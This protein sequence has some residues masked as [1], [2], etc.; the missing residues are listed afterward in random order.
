[1]NDLKL[2]HSSKNRLRLFSKEIN[3]LTDENDLYKEISKIKDIQDFRINKRASCIIIKHKSKDENNIIKTLKKIKVLKKEK[4]EVNT[5]VNELIKNSSS[6]F[7]TA[8]VPEFLKPIVSFYFSKTLLKEGFDDLVKIGISSRFLEAIAVG[9]SILRNDYLSA[10]TTN[11]LLSLGEYIEESTSN[12]SDELLKDLMKPKIKEVWIDNEGVEEL[13]PYKKLKIGNIVIINAGDMVPIDGT[14]LSG[15]ALVNQSSMTGEALSVKKLRGDRVI[16]GTLVEEGRIKVWAEN[17]GEDTA[18]AKITKYIQSSLKEKSLAQKKANMLAEKLV[19]VT[20]ALASFAY[21]STR[22][23]N[24]VSAVLQAD[25]SCALKLASP[26]TF[27]SSIHKAGRVGIMVKGAK[28]IE[29]LSEVDTFVF[30][31]TGTLTK[32]DL[33][34]NDVISFDKKWDKDDILSLA[35]SAEEHYFHPVA[36]AIVK[37]AKNRNFVH[38]NH[39]EVDFI[40]AHGVSTIVEGNKRVLIGSRHFLEDDEKISFKAYNKII[41]EYKKTGRNLLFVAYDNKLLAMISL[42]DTIREDSKKTI[43]KLRLNGVKNIIMLTGDEEDKA[44]E[45]AKKLNID[46]VYAQLKPKQ[47]AEIVKKLKKQGNKVAFVGDGINDAPALISADVGI[48]MQRAAE[49]AGAS[50]DIALL[51]DSIS[52]INEIKEL[53]DKTMK[54]VKRNFN[55]TVWAN[56]SILILASLGKISPITT[57]ILHNGTTVALLLNAIKGIKK[58]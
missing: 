20:I 28:A 18:V 24:R 23:F 9:I 27:K 47:K 46:K 51:V 40:V 53:S 43:E 41:Q 39:N 30:D 3:S 58:T 48:N 37:A 34:V 29:T 38:V 4:E 49:I 5:K 12:K 25:Y 50:S 8:L 10:N 15:I 19:P 26:V 7:I 13:I 56:S 44:K 14:I 35:A 11:A 16:S 21:I 22:D 31:K 6:I 45:I 55:I 17:V 42:I 2:I 54:L 52:A 57:A 1:M 36:E 32:G 33:E